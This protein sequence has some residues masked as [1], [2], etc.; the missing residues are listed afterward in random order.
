L[1]K[2]DTFFRRYLGLNKAWFIS[3]SNSLFWRKF[4]CSIWR[5]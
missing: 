5:D 3:L 2:S 1:T 4:S